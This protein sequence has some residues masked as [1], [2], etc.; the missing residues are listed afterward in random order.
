MKRVIGL[1]SFLVATLVLDGAA[2]TS[3]RDTSKPNILLLFP[4]EWRFDWD[5]LRNSSS[6]TAEL[7]VPNLRE[8]ASK[9]TRFEHAYVPAPVCAPS[10]SCL[11]AGREFDKAGVPTNFD[12]DYPINQ[13]T[14]YTQLQKAGYWTMATGK[15][16][17][18]KATQLGY[19]V[20]N[21]L[22]YGGYHLKE[23]GFS[24]GIR[25]SGKDDVIDAYPIPHEAYGYFLHN[26]T[27]R[28]ANASL[29]NAFDAHHACMTDTHTS[30]LCSAS[31]FP[32]NYYEDN[33]VAQNALTLL[34]RKPSGQPW[35]LHVSFP[36]PHPPFLVTSTM[37]DSVAN[38]SWPQP[39]D[40][41]PDVCHNDAAPHE[42]QLGKGSE[43]DRC[44]YGAEIENLDSLFGLLVDEVQSMGELDNTLVCITSDHG[45]MLGDHNAEAKSKPWEASIG[46][47]LLCF[48]LDVK[49]GNVVD[50]PVATLDLGA[51]FLDY[52]GACV[53]LPRCT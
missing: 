19:K 20:H 41:K 28:L 8:Y 21:Y 24:D 44:N 52:A 37:G 53:S 34:R 1:A 33:W 26:Q 3:N 7:H 50:F 18:T 17:L 25:H 9:G 29:V 10:R 4:D 11:A 43:G 14:F 45:D 42:P 27:V 47:P 39:V 6:A 16:D 48:G 2:A 30:A 12:N 35:F 23:L 38:R 49:A 13:T 5:G 46:V 32:Q 22:P 36:G 31:S 15:D 40:G 51:T